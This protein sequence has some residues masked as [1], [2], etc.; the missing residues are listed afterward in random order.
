MER[1]KSLSFFLQID[2]RLLYD[3]NTTMFKPK[4]TL[5]NSLLINIR[6]V[7]ELIGELNSKQFTE[8][9]LYN[10]EKKARILSSFTSTKIEGNPLSLTDVK[11]IL[12]TKPKNIKDTEKEVINYNDVVVMLNDE[13][14]NKKDFILSD[15][16]I[17]KIQGIVTKGLLSSYR[18]KYRK[19][20]VFVNNPLTRE[21]IYW[22]TDAKDVKKLMKE[23]IDFVN[24]SEGKIDPL[25]LAGIFHKQS[26]VIHPFMDGNGR[27]TRLVTK[28]LLA[29]LGINTFPL[30]S[31]ENYYNKDVSKYFQKVGVMGNYY[32]IANDLDFT[33][34]LEYFVE[35]IL[36]ELNRVKKDLPRYK[37]RLEPH[38]KKIV[39]YLRD[40]GSISSYEYYKISKR[41]KSTRIKDFRMLRDRGII[42][43]VGQGKATYYVLDNDYWFLE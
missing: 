38:E 12:K 14:K 35:G 23:L 4:Y 40:N 24:K 25:I 10:L 27:T 1:C 5:T 30:F 3:Y 39:E 29:K 6:K 28:T 36:D 18:G 2:N 13:I 17:C 32:D 34:W 42:K 33:E 37:E 20:P 15:K 43:P 41:A 16:L 26:V 21:T 8:T 22:P 31:F 19:E 9:V 11:I 7:G